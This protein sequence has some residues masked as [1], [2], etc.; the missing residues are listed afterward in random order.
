MGIKM[1]GYI[2]DNCRNVIIQPQSQVYGLLVKLISLDPTLPIYI[3]CNDCNKQM[4][5]I[6]Q[7]IQGEDNE[8]T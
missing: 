1:G 3:Y 7:V 6:Q 5:G 2:C 8:E 4:Q